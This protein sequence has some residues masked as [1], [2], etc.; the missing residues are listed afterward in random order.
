MKAKRWFGL[1][2]NGEVAVIEHFDHKPKP[3]DFDC[4]LSA[5]W[6]YGVVE[7]EISIK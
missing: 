2:V 7:V 3:Y 6:E 5:G 4:P 1:T